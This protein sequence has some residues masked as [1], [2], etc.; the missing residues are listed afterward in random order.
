MDEN[1]SAQQETKAMNEC[2]ATEGGVAAIVPNWMVEV[3]LD[4][5]S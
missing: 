1:E 3:E 2:D 4:S 5:H